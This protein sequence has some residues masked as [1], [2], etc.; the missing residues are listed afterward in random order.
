MTCPNQDKDHIAAC[1]CL[2]QGTRKLDRV[3]AEKTQ[4]QTDLDEAIKA[5]VLY[6]DS[7]TG[8]EVAAALKAMREFARK[9]NVKSGRLVRDGEF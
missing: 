2:C 9:H 4:L 1:G 5:L 6:N 3:E 8:T 7:I